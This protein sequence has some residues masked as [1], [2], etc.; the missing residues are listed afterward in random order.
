MHTDPAVAPGITERPHRGAEG[1]KGR[2]ARRRPATGPLGHV[3]ERWPAWV[4][5]L[6]TAVLLVGA[7]AGLAAPYIADTTTMSRADE[8]VYIDAVDKAT[9]GNVAQRGELVDQY[10]LEVLSCR[11]VEGALMGSPCGGPYSRENVPWE[12]GRTSADIHPPTYYFVTASLTRA[13]QV[14]TPVDDLLSAARVTSAAWVGLGLTAVVALCR[15][16]GASRVAAAAVAVLGL[17]APHTRWVATFVTPDA[18]NILAGAVVMLVAVQVVRER[19]HPA[20]MVAAAL[21]VGSVKAQNALTGG[22]VVLLL[23]IVALRRRRDGDRS[24]KPVQAVAWAVG[25]LFAGIV[26]QVVWMALRAATALGPAPGQGLE[27][28]PLGVYAVLYDSTAFIR[29]VVVGPNATYPPAWSAGSPLTI[30]GETVS[31]ILVGGLVALALFASGVPALQSSFAR[32]GLLS[33]LLAGPALRVALYAVDGA[34]F[35]MPVRY[36]LVLFP[37]MLAATAVAARR[38]WVGWL[39]LGVA[40]VFY[41]V[42][43]TGYETW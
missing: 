23:L 20:W 28:P 2:G 17:V 25:A 34:N 22:L 40:V 4:R 5:W 11:G 32:A 7:S 35:G 9:R 14:L 31:W 33:F 42:T 41:V 27:A 16:L 36:G 21:V 39:L 30:H 37:A 43:V 29:G 1:A 13:V 10:A 12:G 24:R 19:L 38:A 8:Y 3:V 15:T 6:V 26:P 18:L